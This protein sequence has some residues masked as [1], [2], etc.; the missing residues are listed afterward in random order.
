MKARQI[1]DRLN[2]HADHIAT[3]YTNTDEVCRDLRL[4]A[5]TL[6]NVGNQISLVQAEYAGM[7]HHMEANFRHYVKM[8]E[9]LKAYGCPIEVCQE[10]MIEAI[11]NWLTSLK[12]GN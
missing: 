4:A 9:T 3:K 11:D 12:G 1:A 8:V 7:K 6:H 5:R 2:A 10:G